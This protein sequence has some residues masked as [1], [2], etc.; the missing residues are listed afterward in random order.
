MENTNFDFDFSFENTENNLVLK[1]K[2]NYENQMLKQIQHIKE[3]T[4]LPKENEVI[5]FIS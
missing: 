4:E 3:L 2:A 5:S 1:E